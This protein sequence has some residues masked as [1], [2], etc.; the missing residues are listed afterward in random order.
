MRL[1]VCE[2]LRD[3]HKGCLEVSDVGRGRNDVDWRV[4]AILDPDFVQGDALERARALMA[5]GVG[6]LQLRDKRGDARKTFE[7]GRAL[8]EAAR[9]CQTLII[10][11]DRLDVAMAASAHGVHLGPNDLP[12]AAAR[13]LVGDRLII[14][15]SAGNS[16]RAG[17]LVAE[18]ADYLGVGAIFEARAVK[19]DA[20]SPQ[21]PELLRAVRRQVGEALP[22]V[23][24]GGIDVQ[25]AGQVAEAGASGVAVIRALCQ[26]DDPQAATSRLRDAFDRGLELARSH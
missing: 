12:V 26:A 22:V 2:Y 3:I 13:R 18:G 25:N 21:G 14:G 11:N 24:I 10:I 1:V 4:Y 6:V 16:E 20:S 15:A 9:G 19:S 8:V 23:G 7:L 5:A 17:A